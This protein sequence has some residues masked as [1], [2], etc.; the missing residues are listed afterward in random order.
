[1]A[2]SDINAS[3]CNPDLRMLRLRRNNAKLQNAEL[4]QKLTAVRQVRVPNVRSRHFS[5]CLEPSLSVKQAACG[6]SRVLAVG[7]HPWMGSGEPVEAA[8][9]YLRFVP[10]RYR[11][12]GP[13]S[14][15]IS[16][17]H[18]STS[19]SAKVPGSETN[20]FSQGAGGIQ[21]ISRWSSEA[22]PPDALPECPASWKDAT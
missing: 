14:E 5:P 2:I 15:P 10:R 19:S 17:L 6:V 22:T 9:Q 1:L 16:D 7:A 13:K 11:D 18:F 20:R 21:A 8:V 4:S 3:G 12:C